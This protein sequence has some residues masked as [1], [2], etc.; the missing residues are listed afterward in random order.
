MLDEALELSA[1]QPVATGGVHQ[2]L[3]PW[4]TS[5]K[6]RLGRASWAAGI[7]SAATGIAPVVMRAWSFLDGRRPSRPRQ[8]ALACDPASGTSDCSRASSLAAFWALST[9]RSILCIVC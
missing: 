3:W 2:M 6:R 9:T 7:A 1:T 8:L 4:A 5:A